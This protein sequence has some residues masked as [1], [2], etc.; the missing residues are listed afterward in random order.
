M[1][2]F[3]WATSCV[4]IALAIALLVVALVKVRKASS[5]GGLM[6]AGSGAVTLLGLC[7]SRGIVSF[8]PRGG[9]EWI[10]TVQAFVPVLTGLVATVLLIA[11]FVTLARAGKPIAA[12]GRDA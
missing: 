5:G 12:G 2:A 11:G 8:A 7:C 3:M 1:Q 6:L 4:G 9:A 10:W